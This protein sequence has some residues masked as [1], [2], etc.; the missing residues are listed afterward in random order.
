M[1]LDSN[2][3]VILARNITERKQAEETNARLV[4]AIEQSAEVIVVTDP[5]S[6][7]QYVNPAFERITGY[8]R[9]E[10][11][12]QTPRFLKSGRHDA[13]FYEFMWSRLTERK[14]WTGQL[15]NRRKDGSLYDA[16]ATITPVLDQDGRIINFVSVS[17]DVTYQHSIEEQL[18]QSQKMQAIGR[19]AGGVA[20][21]FNNILTVIG[22][23]CSILAQKTPADDPR[24]K[25]VEEIQKSSER[26]AA[27]TRQ[28]LAFSRKQLLNPRVLDLNETIT[29]M[30]TMLQRL[31]GENIEL[32]TIFNDSISC[33]RADAGQIEQVIMNLAVNARD[34]MPQGGKLIIETSQVRLESLREPQPASFTPGDYV[35]IV[36][37]D[38]GVGMTPEVKAHL[39][40]PFFTT[41]GVGKGTG[42]GL[43]TCYG[44]IQQSS[45]HILVY[46]E[47]GHGTAIKIYLPAIAEKVEQKPTATNMLPQRGTETI[48]LV[49]DEDALRELGV[50]ILQDSGYTVLVASNGR[51]GVEVAKKNGDHIDLI[52]TDVIMPVLGGKDMFN[53]LKPILPTIPV[54]FMS[55]YTDDALAEHG[56][57]EPGIFFIEKPFSP[58]RFTYKV[59]EILD[60][61]SPK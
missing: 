28:L 48:L 57:L 60:N 37:T 44:I 27:L 56:V 25:D 54:M 51:E 19:L 23:Y 33:V 7:I 8:S 3:I 6:R 21:D 22:G 53:E 34:A 59:R 58:A 15:T 29:S 41:K 35:R 10:A 24:R 18:R 43:A 42:L 49:E 1:P 30:T 9:A 50:C 13:G 5:E 47:S 38:N 2:H 55:G 39:F 20:H 11:M 45:G 32:C 40:E 14:A 17:R 52:V 4:A 36:V 61:L 12:G 16:E 31:I 26:A 46:S